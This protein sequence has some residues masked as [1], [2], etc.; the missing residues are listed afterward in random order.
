MNVNGIGTDIVAVARIAALDAR[1]GERFR[2]RVYSSNEQI[3][4]RAKPA[5]AV[6]LAGRFAAKEAVAKA[7]YQS[8]WNEVIPLNHIEILND[9]EGRPLVTVRAMPDLQ[10]L[11]TISHERDHAI[12]MAAVER[13][14][15]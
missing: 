1:Y 6:H 11:V 14:E 3:Y 12:A 8:G 7:I 5:P 10:C 9:P 4:C 2:R 13:K 15:S